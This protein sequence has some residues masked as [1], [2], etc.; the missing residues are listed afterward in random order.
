MACSMLLCTVAAIA[1]VFAVLVQQYA[2]N[3]HAFLAAVFEALD[4][5]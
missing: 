5:C 4:M 1:V 2:E 3:V